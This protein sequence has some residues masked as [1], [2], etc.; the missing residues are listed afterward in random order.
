MVGGVQVG[1]AG[2]AIGA[3]HIGGQAGPV[4]GAPVRAGLALV[5]HPGI[6]NLPP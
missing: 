3:R 4:H 1:E 5:A 2:Q 6:L